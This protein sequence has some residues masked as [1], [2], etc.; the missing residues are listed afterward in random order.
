VELD[1][2]D[3]NV[4][5]ASDFHST[6]TPLTAQGGSGRTHVGGA[7]AAG[8][9]TA[10]GGAAGS[11]GTA[12]DFWKSE[13][14]PRSA[15]ACLSGVHFLTDFNM[16]Y[17]AMLKMLKVQVPGPVLQVQ[18]GR[19]HV[20]NACCAPTSSAPNTPMQSGC[21]LSQATMW[22]LLLLRTWKG[23]WLQQ[24]CCSRSKSMLSGPVLFSL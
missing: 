7:G 9:L 24:R 2:V 19:W 5:K 1:N 4:H 18:P 6:L 10:V 23:N 8:A 21:K 12:L 15:I 14:H 16:H 22:L 20:H 13:F 17:V 11:G 3:N